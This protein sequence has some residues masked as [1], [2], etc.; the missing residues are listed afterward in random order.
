MNNDNRLREFVASSSPAD[1]RLLV[2][3][4]MGSAEEYLDTATRMAQ[5]AP[6]DKA[7]VIHYRSMAQAIF[8]LAERIQRERGS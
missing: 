5:E 3:Y 8:T 7:R 4:L 1:V 2:N 6:K